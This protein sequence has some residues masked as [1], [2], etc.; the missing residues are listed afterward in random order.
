MQKILFV[1]HGNKCR[2]PIAEFVMKDLVNQAGLAD[3]FR[4]ASAATSSEE[5]W[6]GQG[7]PIYRPAREQLELHHIPY[8]QSKRARQ[9]VRADYDRFD[10][11]IVMDE[12]NRKALGRIMGG[13]PEGKI[14]LLMEY[15][16][17]GPLSV[18]TTGKA[19]T[20]R[21]TREVADPWYTG[22]FDAAWRDILAGCAGLLDYLSFYG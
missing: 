11:L 16:P 1:C 15:A 17:G 18:H 3:E 9:A 21:W 2:S 22:N 4:I 7:S 12:R 5:I 14:H 8:D 13:D 10:L 19:G 6:G 20:G